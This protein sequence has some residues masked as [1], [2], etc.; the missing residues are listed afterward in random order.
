MRL[1]TAALVVSSLAALAAP[2]HAGDRLSDAAYLRAARCQGLV[3]APALAVSDTSAMD[4][5]FAAQSKGRSPR[6]RNEARAVRAEA[7]RDAENQNKRTR[8]AN[9]LNSRCAEFLRPTQVAASEAAAA[10]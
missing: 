2:A 9:E 10:R 5:L 1:V 3:R 8:L 4:E 7:T 6:L